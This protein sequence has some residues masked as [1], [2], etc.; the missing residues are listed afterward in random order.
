MAQTSVPRGLDVLVVGAGPAGIIAAEEARAGGLSVAV[1]DAGPRRRTMGA[2]SVDESAWA[3]RAEGL[4]FK[5][6]RV[7]A[8][9]GRAL[10]WGGWAY[11]F[12]ES[13]FGGSGWP[14]GRGALVT[15]YRAVEDILD[16]Q[17][18]T[19]DDRYLRAA[20]ALGLKVKPKSASLRRNRPWLPT[21][22]PA[23][24]LALPHLAALQIEQRGNRATAVRVLNLVNGETLEIRARAIVLA[25]SPVETA[26]ILLLSGF[27]RLHPSIGKNLVD[28]MVASYL[29]I[30][31][32]RAPPRRGRGL[33]P[34]AAF[35]PRFVNLGRETA[36]PYRGGFSI[37]IDGPTPASSLG[38]ARLDLLG[39][40]TVAAAEHTSTVIHAMGECFP[41]HKRYVDIDRTLQDGLGRPIPRIHLAWAA[42]DR[43]RALDM[44]QACEAFADE[45]SAPGGRL[46]PF[47][48]PL[49]PGGIPHEAGTCVMGASD[50]PTDTFGRLR[51][52][53]NVW[54]ADASVMP[55]AGDRHPTLTLLAHAWRAGC[56][57]ARHAARL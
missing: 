52:L 29:L 32:G 45:L 56:H 22:V 27:R 24:R 50:E 55:T 39:L 40:S 26:R 36:R 19:L 35:I 8:I 57:L 54:I 46:V 44:R 1:I 7:R 49:V 6:T 9:G 42:E 18:G 28:H 2:A 21:D 20:R 53:D 10:L 14:Y 12:P 11:R 15:A 23:G 38:H 17:T 33:F 48:D 16:V 25:A 41:H 30:E 43:R 34:G 47:H 37:E 3:Y 5:W 31:P 4:P 51:F 13:V